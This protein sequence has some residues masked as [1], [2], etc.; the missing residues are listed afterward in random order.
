[1]MATPHVST[2][3]DALSHVSKDGRVFGGQRHGEM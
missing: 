3:I 2:H 1:M